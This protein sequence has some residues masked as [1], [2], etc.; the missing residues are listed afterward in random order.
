MDNVINTIT[1]V[2]YVIYLGL[3]VLAAGYAYVG[4]FSLGLA[5]FVGSKLFENVMASVVETLYELTDTEDL[6]E[7]DGEK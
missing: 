3:L 2:S 7:Q 6:D 1:S 5:L 4:D